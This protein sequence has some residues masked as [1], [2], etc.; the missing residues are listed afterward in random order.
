MFQEGD[1]IEIPLPDGRRAHGW[2]LLISK[3]F[4]DTVGFVVF[5]VAEQVRNEDVNAKPWLDVL[6]L[7]HSQKFGLS[8]W[9]E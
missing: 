2:I 5:G 7:C 9:G 1:F 6:V 8:R 4:K 3:R